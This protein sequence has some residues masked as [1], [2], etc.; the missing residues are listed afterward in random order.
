[1][2]LTQVEIEQFYKL[3]YE[4]VWGINEK[5]KVIPRFP[6]PVYGTRITISQEEFAKIRD[7]MWK[8]P[9]W[10][11]NFLNQNDNGEFTEQERE[12][13]FSWRKNFISGHFAI[14]RHLKNYTVFMH[15][16][17]NVP[18]KLYGVN[19]IS[20]TFKDM[21]QGETHILVEGAIIPFGDKII[22]DTFLS[23]KNISFGSGM[24]NT[25][26]NDYKLSKDKHG[27]ITSLNK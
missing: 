20:D 26:N 25:F 9:K 10:I 7:K 15:L 17:E 13:I 4:L 18:I 16:S 12:I 6:K 23:L 5:Q 11:D 8:N 19:G 27:I 2:K 21:F 3:W 24:L 1:M 22:Y 14:M